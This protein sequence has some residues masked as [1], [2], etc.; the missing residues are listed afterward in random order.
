MGGDF[1][2]PKLKW[3]EGCIVLHQG[4][5]SQEELLYRFMSDKFLIN[6]VDKPTRQNNLLDLIC[7]NVPEWFGKCEVENNHI[8]SDHKTVTCEILRELNKYESS[9]ETSNIY[10]TNIPLLKIPDCESKDWEEYEYYLNKHDWFSI[11]DGLNLDDKTELFIK[12]I[13]Q[14]ANEVFKPSDKPDHPKIP[15]SIRKLYRDKIKIS[16][17]ID[18]TRSPD[19]LLKLKTK[20]IIIEAELSANKENYMNKKEDDVVRKIKSNPKEFY[21]YAKKKATG[22]PDIGPLLDKSG[23]ITNDVTRMT[24]IL[25]DQ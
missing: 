17:Q 24:R 3:H 5:S 23:N 9:D 10:S 15:K 7:S 12:T 2:F 20:L 11:S 16:K 22:N 19:R 25:S 4:L 13:E 1:N 8:Y 21:K 14:V 18:S 6:H